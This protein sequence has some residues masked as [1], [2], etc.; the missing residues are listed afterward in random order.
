M[1]TTRT[2]KEVPEVRA[3]SFFLTAT[4][5]KRFSVIASIAFSIASLVLGAIAS[6]RPDGIHSMRAITISGIVVNSLS[7]MLSALTSLDWQKQATHD[8]KF[9]QQ[10]VKVSHVHDGSEIFITEPMDRVKRV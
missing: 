10:L 3:E 2:V 1:A 8:K 4:F 5:W 7:I 6:L 9:A